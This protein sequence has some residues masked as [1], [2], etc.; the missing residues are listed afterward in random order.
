MFQQNGASR[1]APVDVPRLYDAVIVGSGPNG[2]AAANCL[3]D[4]GLSV[5]VLEAS[6]APGGGMRSAEVTEPG[7]IHDLCSAVHPFGALSPCFSALE[8]ERWGLTWAHPEIPLAHPLEDG[9]AAVLHRSLDETCRSLGPDGEAYRRLVAPFLDDAAATFSE[10]LRAIRLPRHV[11]LMA[12][13]GAIGMQ[14]C[15]RVVERFADEP[16]RVLFAGLAAHSI[17]PLTEPFTAA[18]GLSLA[19]AAHHVGWP[20]A[21]GGSQSIAT[22]LVNRLRDRGGDVRASHPV[23]SLRDIP[24]ARK[25]LFD[26]LPAQ[27]AAIAGDALPLGYARRLRRYRLGPGVFKIDWALSGPIPWSA[28]PCRRAGTV[29]LGGSL[30]EIV[31]S[32]RRMVGG[33]PADRPFVLVAQQSLVDPR[34]APEGR[35]TG[36]AY[37]HVPNGSTKDMTAAIE[38]QVERYAPGFR[39]RILARRTWTTRDLETRNANLAGGDIAGG[40]NEWRQLLFRP[41]ARVDPYATPNP[42]IFICS[43][44]TPP[45]GG[46]HGMCGY[47]A[48]QSVLWRMGKIDQGSG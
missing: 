10:I 48:A 36:W 16:A 24:P 40:S 8:L 13:F 39:D 21:R 32:E 4:A 43:S 11:R 3:A 17:R 33:E 19:L 2:L 14:P 22:A 29:H 26:L 47:G 31:E 12:R 15:T 46:V 34:R 42:R 44:A 27:V 35:H 6:D 9:R 7:F 25:V 20:V 23:R 37:C 1:R 30:A 45:G 38:A 5:L 28:E 18:F 41:V